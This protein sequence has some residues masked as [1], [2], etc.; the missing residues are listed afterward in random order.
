VDA[1]AAEA[2]PVTLG[3]RWRRVLRL[4]DSNQGKSPSEVHLPI[5]GTQKIMSG[6][7]PNA[8]QLRIQGSG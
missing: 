4:T 5:V 6:R 8:H 3:D 2:M 7:H 1:E